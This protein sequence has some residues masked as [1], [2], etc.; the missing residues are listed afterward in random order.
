MRLKLLPLAATV[1]VALL[2]APAFAHLKAGQVF[3]VDNGA[4]AD[5]G[6]ISANPATGKETK[7]AA[8]DLAVNA[9]SQFFHNLYGIALAPS[10]KLVLVDNTGFDGNG[11]VIGVN[12]ANGKETKVSANDM[13]VNASNQLFS[14]PS[15]IVVQPSGRILVTD[16]SA[17]IS[18][19]GGVIA[20]NPKNGAESTFSSNALAVNAA[21]QYFL[22][23]ISIALSPTGRIYVLDQKAFGG[24]GGVISVNP[25]TGRETKVAANNM[26][27][28]ASSQFFDSPYGVEVVPPPPSTDRKSV[29]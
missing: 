23:P 28:N 1:L 12:P 13:A 20:V 3:V 26:A 21:S 10:G 19:T 8:N 7:V 5:G 15:A 6:V 18:S 29:V 2:P 25:A 4:F 9:S 22:E 24:S 11:G 16:F 14:S 17:F 27:V